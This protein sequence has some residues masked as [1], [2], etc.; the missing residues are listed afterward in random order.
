MGKPSSQLN[1]AKQ[2]RGSCPGEPLYPGFSG[3][4]CF[5]DGTVLGFM[6]QLGE[7]SWLCEGGELVLRALTFLKRVHH[8]GEWVPGGFSR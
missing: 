6:R 4:A 3:Y 5:I 1:L 7:W 2:K 8:M